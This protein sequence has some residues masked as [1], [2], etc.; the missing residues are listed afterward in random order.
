MNKVLLSIIPIF[1]LALSVSAQKQT[2]AYIA[3]Y[4]SLAIN[5]M[6]TY[7]IPASIVLGIGIH[8]SGS[9]TSK[10]CKNYHNHFGVKGRNINSKGKKVSSYRKFE[11]DLAAYQHFA[12][13]ISQKKYYE[14]LKG[15]TDVKKWLHAIKAGGYASSPTWIVQVEIIIKKHDLT[16]FDQPVINWLMPANKV[17]D[18]LIVV[19]NKME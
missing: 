16:R 18:S 1:C 17:S 2:D 12:E 7:G 4:D 11:S 15:S 9:G 6:N 13:M 3:K 19:P 10:L 5:I 14:K 8:E